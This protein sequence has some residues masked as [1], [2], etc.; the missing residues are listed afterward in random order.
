MFVALPLA[1]AVAGC[2]EDDSSSDK[3]TADIVAGA[4]APSGAPAPAGAPASSGAAA[5]AA[6]SQPGVPAPSLP[7]AGK[8]LAGCTSKADASV[9]ASLTLRADNQLTWQLGAKTVTSALTDADPNAESERFEGYNLWQVT[10]QIITVDFVT[11]EFHDLDQDISC[12]PQT[13]QID[14]TALDAL[15]SA[16]DDSKE[17]TAVLA[18]CD[19]S[20]SGGDFHLADFTVRPA[21]AGTGAILEGDPNPGEDARVVQFLTSIDAPAGDGGVLAFKGVGLEKSF[22]DGLDV[23]ATFSTLNATPG[24]SGKSTLTWD[25]K[26]GDGTA[27]P[28]P[29][30]SCTISGLPGLA[31]AR[32]LLTAPTAQ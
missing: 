5:P 21:I 6:T 12:D 1:L 19:V 25:A 2:A 22:I 24:A 4:P 30:N 17:K 18:Q 13:F 8:Q 27:R 15:V 20:T 29:A 10:G 32:S 3:A 7:A 9:T 26:L 11:F 31:L 23:D 14:R 16:A 28:L